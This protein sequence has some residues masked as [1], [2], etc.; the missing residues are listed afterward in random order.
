MRGFCPSSP[1]R[2]S[3][4]RGLKPGAMMRR[5]KILT[6]R[7]RSVMPMPSRLRFIAI[8][9][10]LAMFLATRFAAAQEHP[11]VLKAS[12]L[13]DGKGKVLH[14]KIIVVEGAKIASVDGAAPRGAI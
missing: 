1:A 13:L 6:N 8:Q 7:L 12:T 14:N 2:P 3:S 4:L 5:A 10:L 11:I 9:I